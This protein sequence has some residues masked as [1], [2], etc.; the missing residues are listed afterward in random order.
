MSINALFMGSPDFALPVLSRLA[1]H[2]IVIGVFTQPDRPAGRGKVMTAPPVKLMA[3]NLSIPVY[4]PE[5]LSAPQVQA[6]LSELQPDLIVVAAYGQI[7]RQSV[8]DIP[9]YGCIN[10]HASLL[11]RWRGASPIQAAILSGDNQTGVTIM[12]MEKGLDTGAIISQKDIPILSTDTAE[13]LSGKLA[14][15]GADLLIETLPDYL[16]GR[17]IPVRQNDEFSTYAPMMK[18]EQALL[19]FAKDID[20]LERSVRAYH[21]WPCAHFWLDQEIIKVHRA[22][23]SNGGT[24]LAGARTVIDGYPAIRAKGGWLILD[25]VQPAGKKPMTGDVFLRGARNWMN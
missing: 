16:N 19:D 2:Y 8:L 6:Q 20:Y 22:H 25:E 15:L 24:G 18:K 10:V 7:L 1:A 13:S 17:I 11:P 4:Q 21:S 14:N 9:K 3:E 23:V 12:Q 5:K